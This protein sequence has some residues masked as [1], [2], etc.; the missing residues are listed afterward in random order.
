MRVFL[1][2]G[3]GVI[4]PSLISRLQADGRTVIA[5]ARSDAAARELETAGCEV[6]RADALD[7]DALRRVAVESRS[8]V[9]INQLTSLPKSFTNPVKPARQ[10]S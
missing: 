8:E 4:G 6:A 9:I 1:A 5:L 2:G 7:L 3:S 10:P